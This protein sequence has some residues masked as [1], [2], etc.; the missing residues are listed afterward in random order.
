MREIQITHGTYGHTL[1][2]SQVFSPDGQWVIYDTRNEDSHISRTSRIEKVNLHTGEVVLLYD[3]KSENQFGPG[4][5]AVA[6]HPM[7]EEAIFIHGLLNNSEDQPYSF[8]R[9]FGGLINTDKSGGFIHADGRNINPPL[10][11]GNLRGGTHAHTWS[12]DGLAISFTYNDYIMEQREKLTNGKVKDL[13]T[14]GMM[15]HAQPPSKGTDMDEE[16]TGT[17]FAFVTAAVTDDPSPGSDAIDRAFDEC[18]IGTNGY[19]KENGALQERAIAFQGNVRDKNNNPI[20]EIFVS[21]IP[22]DLATT[23]LPRSVAG[24]NESRPHPPA[25]VVQRRI[26]FTADRKFAGIQGPRCRLRSSPD[27]QYIYFH[28]KDNDGIVQVYRVST[29]GGVPDQVTFFKQSISAQYNLSADGSKLS[30]IVDNALWIVDLAN[31]TN[32][33]LMTGNGLP[34][35]GGALWSQ[36]GTL[37]VFNRYVP[38]GENKYLQIFTIAP[39]N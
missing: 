19:V 8:T 22:K 10:L 32:E 21:D 15:I 31:G 6:Y 2:A 7:R 27:G 5:G 35:G 23:N 37:L 14:T 38:S 29:K 9:R 24:T 1:N 11:P 4:V 30:C 36:D 25:S 28:M 12:S 17:Y 18:W 39:E 13:R 26:T 16:F 33:C 3:T 34:I 20:T